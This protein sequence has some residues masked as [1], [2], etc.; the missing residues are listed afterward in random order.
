VTTDSE[1]DTFRRSVRQPLVP[2]WGAN[3]LL[4]IVI[5]LAGYWSML[6]LAYDGYCYGFTDGKWP[7][8]FSEHAG[9]NNN[10]FFAL[11]PFTFPFSFVVAVTVF[12]LNHSA[13]RLI[14]ARKLR[15]SAALRAA[16]PR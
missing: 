15:T 2:P 13:G 14:R 7:C 10:W 12:L 6:L 16:R 8:S 3:V 1:I 11:A 4:T 5:L 9:D